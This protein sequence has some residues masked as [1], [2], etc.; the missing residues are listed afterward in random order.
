MVKLRTMHF[1]H[2]GHVYREH[3]ARLKASAEGDYDYSLR[4]D[5]DPR[6]TKVGAKLRAWSID[7]LPNVWNILKGTM[8]L[9]GPR[10][11]VMD[12]AELIGLDSARFEVKPGLTGMAQV[13]GRDSIGLTERTEWDVRYVR[14]RSLRLDLKIILATVTTVFSEPGAT[15]GMKGGDEHSDESE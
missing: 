11:I 2:D 5:E 9:V 3:L 6:V 13:H 12:E 15:G 7:E 4:I 10:P 8:S 14:E 1:D